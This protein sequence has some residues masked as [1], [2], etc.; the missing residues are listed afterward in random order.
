[1]SEDILLADLSADVRELV[2]DGRMTPEEGKQ[3]TATRRRVEKCVK[4]ELG[5]LCTHKVFGEGYPKAPFLFAGEAPGAREDLTG[6]PFVGRS[7]KLLRKCMYEVGFRRGDVYISNILKCRPPKNK[8]PTKE[9]TG[10]CFLHLWWQL[11]TI[12]PQVIVGIGSVA[13]NAFITK[14]KRAI[15]SCRGNVLSAYAYK[16]VPVWHPSYVIRSHKELRRKELV[17]DLGKAFKL[18][19]PEGRPE[20]DD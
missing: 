3:W 18:V 20:A 7:G 16:F 14:P 1:V 6:R 5:H 4:C 10:A 11:E 12:K 19:Y 8:N 13:L 17:K 2:E 15:G 9:Q